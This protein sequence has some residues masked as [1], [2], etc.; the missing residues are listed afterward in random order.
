MQEFSELDFSEV[1]HIY[2]LNGVIIP[3]VSKIIEP[4]SLATYGTVNQAVLQRAADRGTA[5]HKAIENYNNYGIMDIDN[6]LSGYADAYRKW[7][8]I[9]VP[10]VEHCEIRFY[11]KVMRYGGTADCLARFDGKL[12]LIDY[13]TS[14]K[15][16]DKNY[17]LQ[18]EAYVQALSSHGIF[19][20]AKMV[21]HLTKDGKFEEV[22]YPLK[23]AEAW[24]VFGAC[25][26]IYDYNNK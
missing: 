6:E 15:V 17:R 19:V 7:Y 22:L 18:L 26:S 3:S 12:W 23:D 16:V 11:H 21:L 20:D 13:K 9:R 24:R 14:Y 4:V 8:D 1:D 5:V 10:E 2:R 25:K